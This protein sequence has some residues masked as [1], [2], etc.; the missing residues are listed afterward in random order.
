MSGAPSAE[1]RNSWRERLLVGIC[2]GLAALLSVLRKGYQF[3]GYYADDQ[4]WNTLLV[5]R[6]HPGL[7]ANDPLVELIADRYQS[8]LFD[9]ITALAPAIEIHVA[10]FALFLIARALT[11]TAVYQLTLTLTRSRLAG[12]F[13]AF[14][15]AGASISYFGGVNFVETILTPRGLALPLALFGLDAFLRRRPVAMALWLAVCL[16]VHPVTGINITGAIAFCGLVFPDAAPRKSFTVALAALALETLGIAFRT[17]QLGGDAHGLR[18][19]A[20]WAEVIAETVGPWVYLHLVRLDFLVASTWVLV[21][22]AIGAVAVGSR[23]LRSRL[24]RFSLASIA[25][26]GVHAVGVDVLNVRLLLQ[27][28]PQR[29]TVALAALSVAAV[30]FWIAKSIR[31]NDPL[32][33]ALG[34]AFLLAGV[35]V[36]DTSVAILFGLLLAIAWGLR[37]AA[38]PAGWRTALGAVFVVAILAISWPAVVASFNLAPERVGT[39]VAKLR[40]LG[41]DD[42]WVTVQRHI[43]RH[44]RVG[45]PVMAPPA[46]SPRVFAQRPSTLRLKMQSFTHVS[47]AYAFEFMDWRRDVGIPMRTAGAAEAIEIARRAGAR[48]LVLDERDTPSEPGDPAPDFRAGPYRAFSLAPA[49]PPRADR[50]PKLGA[51]TG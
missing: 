14:L 9:M 20:A 38:I 50:D 2:V 35:L 47:R 28:S 40:S 17:G 1:M 18:F 49:A 6:I 3:D 16:Y 43:R 29:A 7:L 5:H 25:A 27:A 36:Q 12:V 13:S 10:A 22:G 34:V 31:A 37:N 21:F 46:L 11:C 51:I 30:G 32:R 8:G 42:D 23:E 39:R 15:V 4:F 26:L 44:S 48:W 24:S 19:D 41:L 45:E 33:R